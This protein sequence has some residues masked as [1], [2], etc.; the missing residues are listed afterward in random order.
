MVWKRSYIQIFHTLADDFYVWYGILSFVK[1]VYFIFQRVE[2]Q[3]PYHHFLKRKFFHHCITLMSLFIISF[4]LSLGSVF[5][6]ICLCVFFFYN[7]TL[8]W[9]LY[10]CIII[11]IWKYGI[12]VPFTLN[13][14]VN[15]VFCYPIHFIVF[16]Y[17][18]SKSSPLLLK[19]L[20]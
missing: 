9:L 13:Y 5:Y 2:N 18:L 12:S 1:N 3:I 7:I 14:L 15:W 11:L 17:F 16:L 19:I 20:S 8:F 4:Y 6:S 10:F